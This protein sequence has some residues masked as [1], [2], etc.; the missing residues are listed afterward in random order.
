M[1]ILFTEGTFYNFVH[2]PKEPSEP[3]IIGKVVP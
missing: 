2:K 1:R 3:V